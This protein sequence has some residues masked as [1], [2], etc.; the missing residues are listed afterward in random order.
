MEYRVKKQQQK[1]NVRREVIFLRKGVFKLIKGVFLV[2]ERVD[3]ASL[4]GSFNNNKRNK[5]EYLG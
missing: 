1:M 4:E 5:V 3:R 2:N